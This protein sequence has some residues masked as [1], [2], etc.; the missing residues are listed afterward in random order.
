MTLDNLIFW[1]IT[2]QCEAEDA[3][4]LYPLEPNDAVRI[5]DAIGSG[6]A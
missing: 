6:N 1:L 4:L 5:A 2:G 3:I